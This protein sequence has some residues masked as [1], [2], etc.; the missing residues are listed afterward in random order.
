MIPKSIALVLLL[1]RG[2]PGRHCIGLCSGLE[3]IFAGA[4]GHLADTA[5]RDWHA[6]LAALATGAGKCGDMGRREA[7]VALP[8]ADISGGAGRWPERPGE[9]PSAPPAAVSE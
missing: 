9:T 8:T 6:E 1:W 5:R 7:A 2:V 3:R 4:V